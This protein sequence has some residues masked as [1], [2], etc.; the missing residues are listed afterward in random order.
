MSVDQKCNLRCLILL[1]PFKK[2]FFIKYSKEFWYLLIKS[3]WKNSITV[4]FICYH[5]RSE[6]LFVRHV[7][8]LLEYLCFIRV[9][10]FM[11]KGKKM[12]YFFLLNFPHEI[13]LLD[14]NSRIIRRN[15]GLQ[16]WYANRKYLGHKFISCYTATCPFLTTFYDIHVY[17]YKILM[18]NTFKLSLLYHCLTFLVSPSLSIYH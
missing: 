7:F 13:F 6:P 1:K 12:S 5:I 3:E 11:I 15:K 14:S 18:K 16:N 2:L 9:S 17:K 8:R 4:L 10:A